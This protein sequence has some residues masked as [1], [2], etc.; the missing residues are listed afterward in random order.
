MAKGMSA[1]KKMLHDF[2]IC[3][4]SEYFYFSIFFFPSKKISEP[5]T[6]AGFTQARKMHF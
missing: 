6:L 1:V 5:A 2:N 4:S 3:Q